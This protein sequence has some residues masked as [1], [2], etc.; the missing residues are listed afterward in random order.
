MFEL[1]SQCNKCCL[2]RHQRPLI[3]KKSFADVIW[4]GLSA[5]KIDSFQDAR[6]LSPTTNSGKIISEIEDYFG[7]SVSFYKT[8]LVK[9]LPLDNANK[10]RYPSYDEMSDCYSN[11]MVELQELKPKLVILLGK[12]VSNFITQ[13]NSQLIKQTENRLHADKLMPTHYFTVHHPSYIY[14]YR[15]KQINEYIQSLVSIIQSHV[16]TN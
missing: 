11:L 7:E 13:Q 15:R 5:K 10:L 9:C 16:Y 3:E 6:P 8:N 4:V 12:L 14:V 1:L 2:C